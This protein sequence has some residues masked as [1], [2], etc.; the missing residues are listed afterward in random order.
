MSWPG[1]LSLCLKV[2]YLMAAVG[3][4]QNNGLIRISKRIFY[5][6]ILNKTPQLGDFTLSHGPGRYWNDQA[7]AL[8]LYPHL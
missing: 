7:R 3:A 4:T 6:E 2:H 8:R 1:R 5:A